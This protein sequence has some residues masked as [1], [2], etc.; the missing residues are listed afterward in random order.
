MPTLYFM[1]FLPFLSKEINSFL[2]IT[3]KNLILKIMK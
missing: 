3:C 1:T 2:F